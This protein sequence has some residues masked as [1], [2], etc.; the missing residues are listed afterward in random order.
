MKTSVGNPSVLRLKPKACIQYQHCQHPAI[1]KPG[2]G[3][4]FFMVP[5][6]VFWIH[7]FFSFGIIGLLRPFTPPLPLFDS[8]SKPQTGAGWRCQ[9]CHP[10]QQSWGQ[11]LTAT[12]ELGPFCVKG[13]APKSKKWAPLLYPSPMR[14]APRKSRKDIK[15]HLIS[16]PHMK[17]ARASARTPLRPASDPKVKPTHGDE[18]CLVVI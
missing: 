8:T 10:K 3:T 6:W 11:V 15:R 1:W 4:G 12:H 9:V 16:Q 13:L 17:G 14:L 18:G 7:E 5:S 2:I